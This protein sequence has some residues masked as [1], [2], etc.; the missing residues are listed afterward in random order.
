MVRWI[1]AR[2]RGYVYGK[3]R[4][5]IRRV[6]A[7]PPKELFLPFGKTTLTLLILSA[8]IGAICFSGQPS[9]RFHVSPGQILGAPVLAEFPFT[10]E[11]A[12]Q[13]QRQREKRAMRVAPVYKLDMEHFNEFRRKV[14]Q[15]ESELGVFS[16]SRESEEVAQP[17]ERRSQLLDL[18]SNINGRYGFALTEMDLA[19]LVEN[20][21]PSARHYLLGE[22]LD[23]MQIVMS[24]GVVDSSMRAPSGGPRS[25][26]M[27]LDLAEEVVGRNLRSQEDALLYLR[28]HLG[29]LDERRPVTSALFHIL[30][31]GI[32]PNL[33]YDKEKTDEKKDQAGASVKPVQI[34]VEEGEMIIPAGI[35][36]D[37]GALE[38]LRAYR[39]QLHRRENAIVRVGPLRMG[40]FWETF[41]ILTCA[42]LA[43]RAIYA[44]RRG[45]QLGT[46]LF[47]LAAMLVANLAILRCEA[48]IWSLPYF[49]ARPALF[50]LLPYV[51]PLFVGA[52]AVTLEL[53][54]RGGIAFA[55]L[56]TTFFTL[57]IG[58]DLD[59]FSC[60]LLATLVAVYQC[61]RITF[62]SQLLRVGTLAGLAF[63]V[64]ALAVGAL[65]EQPWRICLGQ[66]IAAAVAGVG[67]GILAIMVLSP[68]ERL[69][70]LTS[71]VRLQELSDFNHRLLRQLQL[72]AP[73][74]YHHSLMVAN[75]AEQAALEIGANSLL[76]RVA[77]YFHDV[78]KIAKPEYFIENQTDGNPHEEKAPR[79]SALILKSHVLDGVE[80]AR[81]GG[82]PPRIIQVMAEH[83]GTTRMQYFYSKAQRLQEEERQGGAAPRVVDE[84][85]YRYGGP[86]PQT[87]EAAI[88]MLVDSCEAASRSLQKVTHQSVEGLVSTIVQEKIEDGQLDDCPLTFRQ[89][90]ALKN[91]IVMSLTNMLHGRI[92]YAP[93]ARDGTAQ[94]QI[95]EA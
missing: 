82:I 18:L 8:A 92:S 21:S 24:D 74:T 69:F 34:A 72:Y 30:R 62:K 16:S 29:A 70:R 89:M 23:I 87:V 57:M 36:A 6:P 35:P 47:F 44:N 64:G 3:R 1:A 83:H 4:M 95:K 14:S 76:C 93:K 59:F 31:H 85:F 79:I 10:Y 39:T 7:A 53:G 55:A 78:G 63:G 42:I 88:L 46:R 22:S 60:S 61:D 84:S 91:S 68:L 48:Y 41:S 58:K 80:I 45:G 56:L 25:Y 77:A 9:L 49:V 40:Q 51:T 13:T 90:R 94:P 50:Q 17:D 19:A 43:I 26:F 38:K 37:G 33:A 52:I 73:G 67:N 71:N 27:N 2:L 54:R 12:I 28:I 5:E 11:S 15:L 65:A 66:A 32:Y 86:K 20:L 75:V 81:V